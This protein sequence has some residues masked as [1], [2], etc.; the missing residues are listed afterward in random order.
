[1]F[2]PVR[3]HF[4][5]NRSLTSFVGHH[6]YGSLGAQSLR[7]EHLHGDFIL[8]VS[9]QVLYLV[10]LREKREKRKGRKVMKMNASE[11]SGIIL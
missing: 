10:A 1:M 7:V 3:Q 2:S 8:C 4:A 5:A 9:L 6:Q 11:I